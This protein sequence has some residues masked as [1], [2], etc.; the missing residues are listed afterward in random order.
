[1]KKLIT[2]C[3]VVSALI[4]AVS[5]P[6]F[7]S[8]TV[9]LVPTTPNVAPGSTV[10]VSVN[11]SDSPGFTMTAI[12]AVINYDPAVFTYVGNSVAQGAFLNDDWGLM[13]GN[14]S[15][16]LRVVGIDW[17]DYNGELLAA[18][19]GTLFAFTLQAKANAPLGPSALTWGYADGGSGVDGFDYGIPGDPES[20]ESID[21]V[22][23]SYGTSINVGNT[24]IV[25]VP[26]AILLGSIGI[27]LVGWLRRRRTL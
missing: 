1:M 5:S 24:A 21:V 16:Q 22:A 15:G 19:N 11:M 2:I 27:S 13:S 8:P 23:P 3:A 9:A 18:G 6:A 26:G 25:P 4:L 17:T 10:N 20:W 14:P 12:S 7:A